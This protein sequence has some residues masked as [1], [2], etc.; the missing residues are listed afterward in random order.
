MRLQYVS[1]CTRY[2]NVHQQKT[3]PSS[4]D[5]SVRG[6]ALHQNRQRH[7]SG[8]LR[9]SRHQYQAWRCILLSDRSFTVSSC[10]VSLLCQMNTLAL[11]P[12]VT[13][14]R[15]R[16]IGNALASG[17]QCNEWRCGNLSSCSLYLSTKCN[18]HF[19]KYTNHSKSR[20]LCGYWHS[21]AHSI[22]LLSYY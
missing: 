19:T 13:I 14:G 7:P 22:R 16:L 15:N 10:S 20:D 9:C 4:L 3:I 6:D 21:I 1:L 2:C 17:L 8:G 18:S 5:G 11:C 12:T